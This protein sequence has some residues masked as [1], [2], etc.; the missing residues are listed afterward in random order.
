MATSGTYAVA[1]TAGNL[2]MQAFARAGVRRVEI[3]ADHIADAQAEA[4]LMMVDLASEIPNLWTGETFDVAATDGVATYALPE[5]LVDIQ[6]VYVSTTV[7]GVTTDR[8]IGS[9]STSEYMGLSNKT[10]EGAP[11]AYWFDR[12]ITPNLTLWP[13]PDQSYAIKVRGYSRFQDTL[14]ANGVDAEIPYRFWDAFVW[15]LAARIAV[16]YQPDRAQALEARA[17]IALDKAKAEDGEDAPL[18]I[19]PIMMGYYQ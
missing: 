12:Q 14:L 1:Y 11:T 5:R 2:A 10:S 8:S 9:L 19:A 13:V 3:T 15:G 7:S 6:T 16:I 4:N 18:R 17:K